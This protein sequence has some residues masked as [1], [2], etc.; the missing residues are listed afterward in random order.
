ML[1]WAEENSVTSVPSIAATVVGTPCFG[2]SCSVK[3]YEGVI[4]AIGK[5]LAYNSNK[6]KTRTQMHAVRVISLC[7]LI[8]FLSNK[9]KT[10]SHIVH[11]GTK[12]EVDE[13]ERLFVNEQ[14][15]PD[16]APGT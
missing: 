16:F 11:T 1:F 4:A 8:G 14:W 5:L 9:Q 6:R 2:A 10:C 12:Q 13:L 15:V 7:P 3:G